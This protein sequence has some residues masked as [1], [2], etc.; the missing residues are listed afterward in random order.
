MLLIAP[1]SLLVVASS[2]ALTSATMTRAPRDQRR[3]ERLADSRCTARNQ[4]RRT[5]I[6]DHVVPLHRTF[7]FKG[8]DREGRFA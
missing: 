7:S 3:G 1:T 4:R 8:N 5:V 2:S 6:V